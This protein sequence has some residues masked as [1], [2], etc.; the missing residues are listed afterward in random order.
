MV[1]QEPMTSLNPLR[2]VGIQVEEAMAV[3]TKRK[4]AERRAAAL[5]AMA[6][7]ELSDPERVYTLYPHE[8][9]GGM[10]QRA[11]L[12]A[13][14]LLKPKLLICDEPT[15]ALDVTIQAQI[16]K[17]LKKIN[18]EMGMG[19]LFISHDLKAVRHLCDRA[20]I[21]HKGKIIESGDVDTL[22][23]NPQTEYTKK[24]I[25]PRSRNRLTGR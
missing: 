13:A 20:L 22:F 1:F 2:K 17:L 6:A 3:H 11:M 21:M 16:L 15:T 14:I 23:S 9:S 25:S 4:K 5:E 10:R 24:L 12:A 7:A 8:L 19:I 18:G